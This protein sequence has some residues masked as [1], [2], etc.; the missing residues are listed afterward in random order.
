[1]PIKFNG[2][3]KTFK[4]DTSTTSYVI[5][6]NRYGYLVHNYYGARVSDDALDKAARCM[7]YR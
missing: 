2:D 3:S 1:M 6:I 4:L 7:V 5:Q